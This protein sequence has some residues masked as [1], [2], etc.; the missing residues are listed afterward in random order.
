MKKLAP[1]HP[2]EMLKEL[3]RDAEMTANAAALRM[4]IPANRAHRPCAR[5]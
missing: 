3:L 2:G 5:N 4:R 1:I